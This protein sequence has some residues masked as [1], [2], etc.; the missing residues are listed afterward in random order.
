MCWTSHGL[1][2]PAFRCPLFFLQ[3]LCRHQS[4]FHSLLTQSGHCSSNFQF[5]LTCLVWTCSTGLYLFAW[6]KSGCLL[7]R[8]V[9]STT[10]NNQFSL[11]SEHS[12][13]TESSDDS[14]VLEQVST[15]FRA[16]GFGQSSWRVW[17]Q[18]WWTEPSV[19]RPQGMMER[20]K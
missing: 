6:T 15:C 13:G 3:L 18:N 9:Q 17:G 5:W 11:S 8:N 4:G 1:L 14:T 19:S 7:T 20:W 2:S 12:V 10:Q 16:K